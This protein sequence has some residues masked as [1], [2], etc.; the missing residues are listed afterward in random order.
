MERNSNYRSS[1][2]NNRFEHI[3]IPYLIV[4]YIILFVVLTTCQKLESLLEDVPVT[5]VSLNKSE[6]TLTIGGTEQLVV[7]VT[8][9][10]ATNKRVSWSSTDSTVA[11][12]SSLGL[13]TGVKE[14]TAT[15]TVTTEDGGF[16]A[17]CKVTVIAATQG[18]VVTTP[19]FSKQGGTYAESQTVTIQCATSGATI[20]YTTD[21]SDP[22][23]SPTAVVG[24]TV[25]V[26]MP[27]TIKAYAY[28]SGMEDSAVATS[29]P[30]TI[31]SGI[32]FVSTIGNDSNQGTK[33]HPKQ[34]IQA[35][36]DLAASLFST[37]EIRVAKGIY[38]VY[39]GIV[40]KSGISV[41]GS[42]SNDFS[43]RS[44][45]NITRIIDKRTSGTSYTVFANNIN[46]NLVFDG[47]IVEGAFVNSSNN[48]ICFYIIGSGTHV[49]ISNNIMKSGWSNQ[50]ATS[51]YGIYIDSSSPIIY[52]NVLYGG[53][54]RN[55]NIKIWISNG[56][57]PKIYNNTLVS[58][59]A[60]YW[61]WVI[62]LYGLECHPTLKNNLLVELSSTSTYYQ[63]LYHMAYGS[64]HYP[65]AYTTNLFYVYPD[66]TGNG[67]YI[68]YNNDDPK[69][70]NINNYEYQAV[71]T[72][73]DFQSLT[74]D[75]PA[76]RNLVNVDP[77]FVNAATYDYRLQA[78]SPAKDKGTDLSA[79]IPAFDRDGN[80]RTPPWSIGAYERD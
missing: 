18:G 6:T 9:Q 35:G 37:G 64:S 59:P 5:G 57:H 33:D 68:Y 15:I 70:L 71:Y 54:A 29:S 23:T 7:T 16:K 22:K 77:L 65:Y 12:V 28:K 21:C 13:V 43:T 62:A 32:V 42:F 78:N 72:C 53:S 60:T 3:H 19:T 67:S 10:D 31:T 2:K 80:P 44:S 30:F 48:T 75:D 76:W 36:I 20:K 49:I 38:Q 52:N 55:G 50:E 24:N 58:G 11:T 8:P 39:S 61:Q 73:S 27:L 47:F 69:N 51:S 17:T 79:E 4:G 40:L 41:Y 14:G 34:T 63:S 74:Y 66:A 45:S 1:N 56:S 25:L 46:R 26:S